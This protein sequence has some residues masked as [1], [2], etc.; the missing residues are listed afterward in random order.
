MAIKFTGP[1]VIEDC[2]GGM[3]LGH[4]TEAEFSSSVDIRR[5]NF[6]IITGDPSSA[7]EN[8]GLP[9]DTS[10]EMIAEALEILR[11]NRTALPDQKAELVTNSKL[12]VFLQDAANSAS[13][14]ANLVAF[15]GSMYADQALDFFRNLIPGK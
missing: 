10:Y 13:I 4:E 8:L 15:S 2:L 12:G 14:I 9:R 11:A 3:I 6:G 7:M 5:C 1:L